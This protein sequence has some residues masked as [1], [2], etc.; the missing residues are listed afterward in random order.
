MLKNTFIKE[1]TS[2]KSDRYRSFFVFFIKLNKK[3]INIFLIIISINEDMYFL[4]F[5]IFF[6][7]ICIVNIILKC[8]IFIGVLYSINL[9]NRGLSYLKK[10]PN[11][12]LDF[13]PNVQNKYSIRKFTVG[14][15]SILVGAT[16]IFGAGQEEAKAAESDQTVTNQDNTSSTTD[17]TE[18]PSTEEKATSENITTDE[19]SAEEKEV[20]E[21]ATT[22][23]QSTETKEVSDNTETSQQSSQKEK[24]IS[25]STTTEQPSPEEKAA[26]ESTQTDEPSTEEKAANESTQTDEPSTEEKAADESTQ[27]D[28]SSAEEKAAD[29]STQ[30]DKS[31]SEEKAAESTQ[32]DESSAEEKAADES[33]QTDKSSS[34][35]KA[36]ESTQT[37]ES[38]SEE[39]E[40]N[41]STETNQPS[42][43]K[44]ETTSDVIEQP[45]ASASIQTISE[46]LNVSSDDTVQA[47]ENI[48]VDT[49]NASEV[50]AIA[51]LIQNDYANNSNETPVA[52]PLNV[53]SA[54]TRNEETTNTLRPRLFAAMALAADTPTNDNVSNTDNNQI[55]EA[56]AI[57]NGYI[58]SPTDATNA[59]NTLSGR[60]WVVDNN[61]GTP[62][63]MSNG[64]SPVPEG[65]SVYM[66]WIDKDGVTSPIYKASTTNSLGKSEASQVGP[67]AYAFDLRT[68]YVD[69]NGKEHKYRAVDG[70]YYRIWIEDYKTQNG[71]TATMLRTAGGF[72]PGSYV[73]SVTGNNIGQFPLIGTN[74][75]RTGIFMGVEPD[76][77]YMT[78]P[79]SEWIHDTQGA[80]RPLSTNSIHG[81]VWLE[82]GTGGDLANSATGPNYNPL[83][84]DRIADGYTVVFSTLTDEGVQAYKNQVE[85]LPEAEQAEATKTLLTDHPEYISATVYGETNAD[86]YYTLHF[87]SDTKINNDYIY[88][89]VMN[90]NGENVLGYSNFISPVFNPAFQAGSSFTPQTAPVPKPAKGGWYNVNFAL[91]PTADTKIDI[92]KYNNTTQPAQ[93]GD[94]VNIDLSGSQLSPLPTHIE[95][96]D[97]NG[98][99]VQKTDDITSYTDGEQK[100][101]FVVP[102]TAK[103]GDVY[104]VYLVS[105]GK[106]VGSDSF[107]VATQE[108]SYHPKTNEVTKDYGTPTTEEDVTG[109]VTI[110]DYPSEKGTPTITVD[111]P[112]TLPDGNTPGTV[113]VPVTVTYPDGTEDH[114]TVPVT[115][116]EQADND[117]YQPT[118]DEVTKDYGTPTT[119]EDVTVAV[120]VPDYPSEKEQPVITVDN[121]DQLPDGNTPGTTEVDVTVTYPDGTKDHVKVPVTVGEEA[122]NDAYDPNVEEVNKDYGTPTTEEDVTGAVTVPDYPSEKEQPVITVDN[123]DQLPDGNTPGT[124]EVDVTVTYPDGTKDHVKV[125]V[126][127]GEETQA[128]TNDPGYDNVTVDPGETVKVP[129]TGDN[130]MPDGT[131]YEIDKSKVPSDWEVTVDHNTGELT[132]KPSEDAVPG[133]SIVI[134]VTVTYPDGSTEEVSTTITVGDVIDIPAPTV[135]PVDDNDT[136]VTGTDG[137]PGNTIVVTFPDGSTSEGN[138][139]KDGNWTVDIPD[140]VDLDKGDVITV[141]EKDK[142]GKVST[143]TK[144]VVGENCDNPSNGDNSGDGAGNDSSDGD[145]SEDGT[146]NDSS[147]GDNSG[148]GAG[149]DSSDGDNSEDGADKGSSNEDNSKDEEGN[150]SLDSNN[151]VEGNKD[152]LTDN[153]ATTDSNN[154]ASVNN[155]DQTDSNNDVSELNEDN[156]TSNNTHKQ[157]NSEAKALPETGNN[158]QNNG[159][160]LGSLFAATGAL[161]LAGKR[162]KN[163]TDKK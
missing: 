98:N 94:T 100:G 37:D 157:N 107:V 71:N 39:K 11:R 97:S 45:E 151:S 116:N 73:N 26:N 46:E 127:V 114:V 40:A 68:P 4:K 19:S 123:P 75:Q 95:W 56:D 2:L 103:A 111:D 142:D 65:T 36:A 32:T 44:H 64:L 6:E 130:T 132:V 115:T 126:I 160:L 9:K 129:Q 28:E 42:L 82:T 99:V 50:E 139:D 25:E 3:S 24:E 112:S 117:A 140:G 49:S 72:L 7:N 80:D 118:T 134:P 124:T 17:T 51:A 120:T 15:A 58:N 38:S 138:I 159:T 74:M 90:P 53:N 109:A 141:V 47:L 33:T 76:G 70:Q 161:F 88:G 66:Q 150:N 5:L 29:E 155:T 152:S 163:R 14:A 30:T 96:R 1:E 131:Q 89:Y 62:S 63:T 106:D 20:S 85:S 8:Y 149:N 57:K 60:A 87:P 104:T 27:T 69:A 137:T 10:K 125:P 145:N 113:D 84:S 110:P 154:T 122:D 146:G 34:E 22:D 101:T 78:R 77:E 79:K 148:D 81:R 52:T 43:D 59:A 23:Q 35:E 16:L 48:G 128:N 41:D 105:G 93:P 12:R 61:T 108:K 86:G 83:A 91:V 55:I 102:N 162:R 21:S 158:E 156:N 54:T 92:V 18:Q 133:T 31:S 143:P 147:D 67:G 144:V 136:E 135:N 121:P 13:L 153:N 119:E